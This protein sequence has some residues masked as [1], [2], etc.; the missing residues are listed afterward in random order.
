MAIPIP[1]PDS[2]PKESARRLLM[3]SAPLLKLHTDTNKENKK[4]QHQKQQDS[5]SQRNEQQAATDGQQLPS[6]SAQINNKNSLS[7]LNL[8][9][10]LIF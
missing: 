4:E 5:N 1:L 7:L 6:N 3:H 2:I 9:E 8:F 10:W